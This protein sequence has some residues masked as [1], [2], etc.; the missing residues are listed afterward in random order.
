MVCVSDMNKFETFSKY[1]RDAKLNGVI[2]LTCWA[3][4]LIVK[5]FDWLIHHQLNY[6]KLAFFASH[7][8]MSF[9]RLLRKK[10]NHKK[11]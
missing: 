10:N 9:V 5:F 11:I 2:P 3:F 8:K 1:L 6:I 7:M 4:K